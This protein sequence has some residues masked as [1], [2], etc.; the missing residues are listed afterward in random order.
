MSHL[1]AAHVRRVLLLLRLW[2]RFLATH[3]ASAS[4]P[5]MKCGSEVGKPASM[6]GRPCAAEEVVPRRPR[7]FPLL[8]LTVDRLTLRTAS[9][10]PAR[11]VTT[12]RAWTGS[13]GGSTTPAPPSR[14]HLDNPRADLHTPPARRTPSATAC[15]VTRVTDTQDDLVITDVKVLRLQAKLRRAETHMCV[16]ARSV[17]DGASRTRTGDLLGAIQA[18]SQLS[19]SPAVGEV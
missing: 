12:D 18:L 10:L 13:C 14:H 2:S 15:L 19:Y 4:P 6:R 5:R 7:E 11:L 1:P 3:P 16:L 8:A 9:Q 17:G